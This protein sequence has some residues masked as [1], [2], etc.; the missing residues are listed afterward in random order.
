MTAPRSI[1]VT[2]GG[3]AATRTVEEARR[4]GLDSRI[5]VV[6]AEAHAPYDRPPLSKQVLRGERPDAPLRDDWSDLDVDLRLGSRAVALRPG[7]RTVLLDDGERLDYDALVV[8]TG[9]RPRTLPGISG[10][11][12][13]VLR[14][15]EDSRSLAEDIRR[16]GTLTIVG[17]GLIGCEVAASARA[18][19]A[20]V[21]LLELLPA[22]LARILGGQVAAE[23]ARM[24]ED[25]G[26]RL[27]CGRSV[28]E[29]RGEGPD[30]ELLLSDGSTL[31]A[32]VVLVGLGVL[33]DT[34]WLDGS[35]IAVD[36][37]VVCTATGRT[38]VDGVWAAGDV[39]RWEHPLFGTHLRMEHW[40]SAADQ[41]TA[42]ARDLAGAPVALAEV[43]YF[44]S[45]QYGS[46]LQILG[47]PHPD[48]QVTLLRVG[49]D[50][51]RLLAVYGRDGVVTAVLG[52]AAPRWV[53][54]MRPLLRDGAPYED[55]LA[56]ARA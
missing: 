4:L 35:G 55:A 54:R 1:V 26:V 9:A 20:D 12:A 31:S 37:G 24:H 40:T 29:A 36:N 17:G 10:A 7:E 11:G 27:L 3:L 23:V 19:G 32:P 52:A 49:P 48:D 43:P 14:T 42:V 33:P 34:E 6:C 30:R 53:M 16:T 46:K 44:W 28:V 39:A 25:A 13:H 56:A 45:D 50:A 41:G 2:G 38:S 21:T 22:P 51:D 18:L 5:T 15:L 47:M 8:A